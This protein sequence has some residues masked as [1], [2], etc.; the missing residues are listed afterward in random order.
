ME[1]F[2]GLPWEIGRECL[3]RV[4]YDSHDNLR[5]VCK[6]WKATVN[7]PQFYRDRK[8]QGTSQHCIC[9][10]EHP[11]YLDYPDDDPKFAVTVFDPL[12]GTRKALPPIPHSLGI[13]SKIPFFCDCV[14]VN[15]KLVLMGGGDSP[16]VYFVNGLKTVFIYDFSS[17]K[18]SRGADMPMIRISGAFAV[19]PE[20]LI[21][22]AGGHDD[23]HNSLISAAVYNVAKDKWR[24]LPEMSEVREKCYGAFIQGKFFVI[25]DPESR[26]EF[27][28]S[29]E[30][31]DPKTGAWATL[32]NMWTVEVQDEE[33]EEEGPRSCVVTSSSGCLY[34]FQKQEGVMEYD[35]KEN[36][37]RAVGPLPETLLSISCLVEWCDKIFVCGCAENCRHVCYLFEPPPIKSAAGAQA[38][39]IGKWVVVGIPENSDLGHVQRIQSAVSFEI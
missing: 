9:L 26:D 25:G 39:T 15:Q 13:H 12:R 22:V 2:S 11:V 7:Q 5:A 1:L 14:C 6:S 28:C 36:V 16:D 31:Y 19:S 8:E 30:V 17:R 34:S 23:D 27:K 4:P 18:W 38:E 35:F 37:W 32:E 29:A 20:G 33:E 10:V 24:L 21:Y 3:L